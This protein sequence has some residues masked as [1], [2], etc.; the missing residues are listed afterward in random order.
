[1]KRA[2]GS[3]KKYIESSESEDERPL[4]R[5]SPSNEKKINP[6]DS[7]SSE[8]DIEN[9]LQNPEKLDLDS[10]FFNTKTVTEFE[11]IEKNIFSGL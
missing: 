6:G 4:K 10:E 9:Y 2:R 5:S 3:V 8:S 1:M 7:S 11:N